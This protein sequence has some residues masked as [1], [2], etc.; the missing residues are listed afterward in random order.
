MKAAVVR[1][2][3]ARPTW[4]E[5][6]SPVAEPGE[7]IVGVTAAAVNPIVL[8]LAS[9]AH[10]SGHAVLPFIPGVDGAGRT[11]DG[12]RLYFRD[13]RSPYG[14]L[15]EQAP[16]TA[17]RAVPIPDGVTD[18][19]AAVAAIPGASC[20]M[21]LTRLAPIRPGESVLV[22][23]ATG[24]AG[25]MAVQ[26][27]RHLGAREVVATGRDPSGLTELAQLGVNFRLSLLE[28]AE[29]LR[30]TVRRL[31]KELSI[32]VVLDYLWGP[33][34][35]VLLSALGG[36]GAPRGSSRVRYVS[37][38]ALA[39]DSSPVASRLLR[40]SGLEILGS[41]IGSA[42]EEEIIAGTREFLGALATEKFR[43]DVEE[44]PLSRVEQ[45]WGRTGG[46]KRLVFTA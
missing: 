13:L 45:N 26:V 18:V 14:A 12:R 34:A 43:L 33:S 38:G 21:P 27:A 7:V 11:S 32:G 2:F 41:G 22:N 44:Q 24:A 4:E 28:P 23:G 15:A 20:W 35:Q 37:I 1:A 3:G 30:D 16:V 40:S 36:P 6:P 39:G 9:G 10:Y 46:A 19:A 5:F 25:R 8:S 42:T 17:S 29:E 31:A